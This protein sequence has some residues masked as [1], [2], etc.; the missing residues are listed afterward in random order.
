MLYA[1]KKR[2]FS[3]VLGKTHQ[4]VSRNKRHALCVIWDIVTFL[5]VPT[6]V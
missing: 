5:G 1:C 3:Y 6:V 2:A 4:F